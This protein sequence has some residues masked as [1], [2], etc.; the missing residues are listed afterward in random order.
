MSAQLAGR[1][2]PSAVQVSTSGGT[3]LVLLPGPKWISPRGAA[4]K[5]GSKYR[6][7]SQEV[8]CVGHQPP[9]SQRGAKGMTAFGA[10]KSGPGAPYHLACVVAT[11]VMFGSTGH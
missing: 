1:A 7:W 3:L 9:L 2:V 5:G 10:Q 6:L 11:S 4:S 8:P